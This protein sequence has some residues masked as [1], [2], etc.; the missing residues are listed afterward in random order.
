MK[1]H[2]QLAL[3]KLADPRALRLLLLGLTLALLL[4]AQASTV[5]ANV[6]PGGA[7][8]GTCTGG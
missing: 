6:C 8:G 1:T 5:Y 3:L 4:L 2:I 7:G